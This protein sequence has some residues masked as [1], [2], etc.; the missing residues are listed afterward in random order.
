MARK[1]EERAARAA[2]RKEKKAQAYLASD[3]NFVSFKNQLNSLGLEIK[4]TPGDGYAKVQRK[5]CF[6]I[7]FLTVFGRVDLFC[8]SLRCIF[9]F[10]VF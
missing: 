5:R 8:K 10:V 9:W 1:R 2:Y 6:N 3:M 4:D 7:H